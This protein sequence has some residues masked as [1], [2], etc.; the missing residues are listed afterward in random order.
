ML[1]GKKLRNNRWQ[2]RGTKGKVEQ[3]YQIVE[4]KELQIKLTMSIENQKS[5]LN[6]LKFIYKTPTLS[7]IV[8]VLIG[9]NS[10][11]CD[12]ICSRQFTVQITIQ[13]I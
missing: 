4:N 13:F 8:R 11:L 1:P 9:G 3:E 12:G 10:N 2:G 5:K 6:I 7:V